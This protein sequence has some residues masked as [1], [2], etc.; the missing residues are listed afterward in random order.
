MAFPEAPGFELGRVS[1]EWAVSFVLA[2]LHNRECF[3]LAHHFIDMRGIVGPV[4]RDAQRTAGFQLGRSEP[5]ERRL[6][7][8]AFVVPLFWPGIRKIQYNLLNTFDWE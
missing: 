6:H 5:E 7:D 8:A 4:S 1:I 3:C 2:T